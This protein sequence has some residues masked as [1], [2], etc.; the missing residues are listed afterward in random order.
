M[1]V[2]KQPQACPKCGRTPALSRSLVE[3]APYSGRIYDWEVFRYECRKWFGLRSCFRGPSHRVEY[4]TGAAWGQRGA[5][6]KW[7]RVV[8]GVNGVS[9]S[10]DTPFESLLDWLGTD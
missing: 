2:T 1:P 6:R 3:S 9:R 4:G 5:A 8:D 7:D 10:P